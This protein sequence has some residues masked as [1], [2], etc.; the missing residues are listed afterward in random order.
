M[1][2]FVAFAVITRQKLPLPLFGVILFAGM[3]RCC[4]FFVSCDVFLFL[5]RAVFM[6]ICTFDE[7]QHLREGFC[8]FLKFMYRQVKDGQCN[9]VHDAAEGKLVL[10][11]LK[12]A[13]RILQS[14]QS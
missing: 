9:I 13:S 4:Y 11:R 3:N 2:C 10:Q 8:L 14:K 12:S 6:R 7:L 5:C 1:Q